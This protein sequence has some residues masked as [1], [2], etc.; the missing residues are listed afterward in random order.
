MTTMTSEVLCKIDGKVATV[1]I[2]RASKMNSIN[3]PFM[4]ELSG[5]LRDLDDNPDVSVIILTGAGPHFGAGYDLKH[6]WGETYGRGPMGA[7][8]M[9]KDCADFEFGPWDCSKPVI[10]MVRGYCLAGSCELAMM[11][12]ITYASDT[13]MFGEPEIRFSTAPPAVIMPWII[14]LKR[15][16]ELLYTG[17]MI[18]AEEACSF[19]MVNKVFPD[20]RLEEETMRYARR[21]AA[22]SLEGLQTTKAAINQSAEIAGMRSAITYGV[23][24][25]GILDSAET[26][27]YRQFE[28]VKKEKGLSAAIRWRESQFE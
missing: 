23:E 9:L 25:G 4:K 12:C 15:T 14:G 16:R 26:E 24:V 2:N 1:T 20:D 21:A 22:I 11:C 28:A 3:P 10:A 5:T 8:K 6:A 19:G 17:D 27:Q 7:R 13:A 18:T